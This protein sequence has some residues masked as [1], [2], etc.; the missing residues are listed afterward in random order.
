M[1]CPKQGC[2]SPHDAAYFDQW[3]ADM[4]ASPT[5][6]A[7]VTRTL[8]LPAELQSTSLL[9]WDGIAEATD[10]LRLPPGGLPDPGSRKKVGLEHLGGGRPE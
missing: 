3:Y 9:T 4:T 2:P 7:I 8:R 5:R 1:T 6:D 10:K